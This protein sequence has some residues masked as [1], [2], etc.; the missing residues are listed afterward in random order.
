MPT[1]YEIRLR[2]ARQYKKRE[3]R[4]DIISSEP[5]ISV[6]SE[7]YAAALAS[8]Q[9]E[10]ATNK[11]CK[12][13][14]RKLIQKKEIALLLNGGHFV[15][16]N[17]LKK[18]KLT[19]S[20]GISVVEL[21]VRVLVDTLAERAILAMINLLSINCIKSIKMTF[22]EWWNGF[23]LIGGLY[24]VTTR[25]GFGGVWPL[26]YRRMS[27]TIPNCWGVWLS[28]SVPEGMPLTYYAGNIV[29]ADKLAL[30]PDFSNLRDYIYEATPKHVKRYIVGLTT[31]VEGSGLGSFINCSDNINVRFKNILVKRP[32]GQSQSLDRFITLVVAIA[33]IGKDTIKNHIY[34]S[35]VEVFASYGNSRLRAGCDA[36]DKAQ[37]LIDAF[38][39]DGGG[40]M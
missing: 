5:G 16:E 40:K 23:A 2:K 29:D 4:R 12:D 38:R 28:R 1:K 11:K 15:E 8:Q 17:I 36:Q 19:R 3:I 6:D 24:S 13:R 27:E 20:G 35:H 33:D 10:R 34:T 21:P 22:E 18:K 39:R 25:L 37:N 26:L 30:I 14:K 7:V 32:A 9:A 31:V